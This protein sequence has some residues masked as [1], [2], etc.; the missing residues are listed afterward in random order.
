MADQKSAP[1]RNGQVLG[2]YPFP[3]FDSPPRSHPDPAVDRMLHALFGPSRRPAAGPSLL[4][5]EPRDPGS[6]WT[7]RVNRVTSM[8]PALAL[9][10]Q[11]PITPMSA[12]EARQLLQNVRRRMAENEAAARLIPRNRFTDIMGKVYASP[13]TAAGSVVGGANVLLAKAMG[14]KSAGVSV[15]DNGIQYESGYFGEPGG[16]F[17]LGNAV[18]HGPGSHAADPNKRY[19]GKDTRATTSEHEAGHAYRYQH[20]GYVT[21]YVR[22]FVRKVLTGEPNPYEREADDFGD[23]KHRTHGKDR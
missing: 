6:A 8:K 7:D 3:R 22:Y 1:P 23:W 9:A 10:Q 15:Q 20:P 4:K 2:K 12:P 5:T 19:D 13:Y 18:L 11:G 14:D 17:T 16:A 21:D